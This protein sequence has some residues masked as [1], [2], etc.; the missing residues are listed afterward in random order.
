MFSIKDKIIVVT[1]G[2]GLLGKQIIS[3]FR[4]NGA[5]AI[6]VDINFEQLGDDDFVMDITSETSVNSVVSVAA[7]VPAPVPQAT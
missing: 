1:G 7:V 4:E 3:T 5:I 6:S 2:N